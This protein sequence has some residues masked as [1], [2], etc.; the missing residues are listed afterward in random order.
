MRRSDGCSSSTELIPDAAVALAREHDTLALARALVGRLALDRR[1]ADAVQLAWVFHGANIGTAGG[2]PDA[3]AVDLSER[4]A[5]THNMW[6]I[7]HVLIE[8]LRLDG[9]IQ[10]G[11]E[12]P[13]EQQWEQACRRFGPEELWDGTWL[14]S[15]RLT[16]WC[17]SV[18][19]NVG[20]PGHPEGYAYHSIR[21]VERLDTPHNGGGQ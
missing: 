21:C 13:T 8:R 5:R 15:G 11:K 16:K 18:P 6:V 1:K 12:L 7:S 17:T 2:R 19:S 14:L 3:R 4:L 20:M 9:R 10:A